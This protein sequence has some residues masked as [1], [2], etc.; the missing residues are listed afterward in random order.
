MKLIF[1]KS[2]AGRK[3]ITLP[4]SDVPEAGL[5][6][7][8]YIR[9]CDAELPQVS[10]L[11][12]VRHFTNLSYLNY[13]VDRNFYPLGS[14][15]MKYNPKILEAIA[16]LEGF[17][18]LHPFIALLPSGEKFTQGSL[19]VLYE[20]Q[21][22]LSDI[23][24]MDRVTLQPL[25]GAH[26]ELTG[27]MLAGAYH[28]AKNNEK[29]YVIIPD[30]SHGTNPA[31]AS[32]AGYEIIT[33]PTAPSGQMD[34]KEFKKNLNSEVAAVIMT[35]PNTL[36][37]FNTGIKEVCDLAHSVDALMYYDG[38]NMNAILGKVKPG[39]IGFDIVHINVHKT[40]GTP[41][42]GGGP[43]AGPVGVK[44]RLIP[45]LPLPIVE[46]DQDG[47]LTLLKDNPDSIGKVAPF[48]G[49]FSVLLKAYAYILLMGRNGLTDVSEKAVLNANYIMERLKDYYELPY[50][51]KCMHECVF[52][53]SRQ[54]AK[55]VHALDIAKFLIDQGFHPPTI[56]FPLI[57]KEAI[58][59]E[60]T[61]TESKE[62]LDAFIDA[63]ITAAKLADKD[64]HILRQAPISTKISRPD[65]VRAARELDVNYI[66]D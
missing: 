33:I 49:N 12:T 47:R 19:Q 29:K 4:K 62:T 23:T 17:K 21:E 51:R 50:D 20:L 22:M 9:S 52:S 42:G 5:P 54:A 64:P 8:K 37:I 11:D 44:K 28:R 45:Y 2:V 36:G 31:S 58:M 13:S 39:D 41:H 48:Y 60:P 26:G 65:E 3:G 27:L 63:M 7:E 43:G 10:E 55:G 56:Y 18:G 24:G 40:F 25:A 14:C 16:S 34:I 35:C 15:T 30:A 59:I 46:K 57:V 1:E 53:A 32:M 6:E 66:E 61:E 38:A